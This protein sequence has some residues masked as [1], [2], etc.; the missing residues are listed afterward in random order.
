MS[1]K[2]KGV[3][4]VNQN[5]QIQFKRDSLEMEWYKR[6]LERSYPFDH[7]KIPTK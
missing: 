1:N 7:S 3:P 2:Y 4:P 5:A 6:E